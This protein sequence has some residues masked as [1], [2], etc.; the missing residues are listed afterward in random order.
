MIPVIL[1]CFIGAIFA[2]FTGMV[3]LKEMT[4]MLMVGLEKTAYVVWWKKFKV[5]GYLVWRYIW[6]ITLG[7]T[8]VFILLTFIINEGFY[9]R[10]DEYVS[11]LISLQIP[12]LVAGMIVLSFMVSLVAP[13]LFAFYGCM[14]M[15]RCPW[16]MHDKKSFKGCAK[17]NNLNGLGSNLTGF[18]FSYAVSWNYVYRFFISRIY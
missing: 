1:A 12:R 9:P 18:S 5:D 4:S 11:I 7:E 17:E 3:I 14:R 15:G 6:C 16:W 8:C 10:I 2:Y 13:L